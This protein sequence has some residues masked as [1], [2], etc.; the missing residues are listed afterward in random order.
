M[1]MRD[2]G[3]ISIDFL[4]GISIFL[5][6]LAF[7]IQFIPGLFMSVS[8]EGSLN[9]VAYRTA[10]I[11]AE[12]PGWWENNT[13]NGTDWELHPVLNISRL[14]L[15]VDNIPQTRQTQTPNLLNKTKILK[16]VNLSELNETIRTAKLGLYDKISGSQIDYGYNIYLEQNGSIMEINDPDIN[17]SVPITFGKI[18]PES[19]DIIKFRRLV[20]VETG[21]IA[22]YGFDELTNNSAGMAIINISGSQGENV[23]IQITDFNINSGYANFNGAALNCTPNIPYGYTASKRTTTSDF[24]S[25]ISLP[26]QLENRTDIL[27]LAFNQTLPDNSNCQLELNFTNMNFSRTGPPY[28]DYAS[29]VEPLYEP[30]TLVVEVW[31]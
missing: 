31:R 7:M 26:I 8:G 11:L 1:M 29:R 12:D 18:P 17:E 28:I 14:G 27:R 23:T 22:G 24:N 6:T 2:E 15:A 20:L 13:N 4:V 5:L 21:K 16:I 30:A 19:Q 3:Q 25:T 9:S 10:T